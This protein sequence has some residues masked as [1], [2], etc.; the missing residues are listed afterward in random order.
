MSDTT[1]SSSALHHKG[2]VPIWPAWRAR[3]RP[4]GT[5]AGLHPAAIHTLAGRRSNGGG[6]RRG[7][8][9]ER[10]G[11]GR[12]PG[13]GG[14]WVTVHEAADRIG[15]GTRTEALT[16]PGF[17]HDVC[18]AVHPM[19]VG[20]PFFRELPL[21]E[22]GLEWVH[23]PV[24]LAH[25]FDDGTAAVLLR[26][27]R[28]DRRRPRSRRPRLPAPHGALRPALARPHGRR[29]GAA[30]ADPRRPLP[31]GPPRTPRAPLGRGPVQQRLRR[32]PRPMPSSWAW[33]PTPSSPWIARPPP[34]SASCWPPPA[35]APAGPLPAAGPGHR[36]MPWR[37]CS[38]GHGGRIQTGSPLR[39]STTSPPPTRAPG[40]DSPPGGGSGGAPAAGSLPRRLE[41][42]PLR[43]RRLQ[44]GLGPV[45]AHPVD[46]PGGPARRARCTWA[47]RGTPSPGP[48]RRHGKGECTRTRSSSWPSP[49][50]SIRPGRRRDAT[51]PGRTATSPTA[52]PGT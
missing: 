37:A 5:D 46:G 12:R 31:H 26:S 25:P 22:H 50:C 33:P 45:R 1:V 38:G 41:G 6:D 28:G 42:V 29:P 49:A 9:A 15:G 34:R 32:R 23:P 8:G 14:A 36:L 10:T 44:G 27:V 17:R 48:P 43:A 11:R 3:P 4:R 2:P 21:A 40:P 24:L 39:M 19:G 52:P 7:R 35:T 13:P 30:A 16:L 20:S 47:G 51:P 18:S